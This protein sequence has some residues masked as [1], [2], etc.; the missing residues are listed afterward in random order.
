MNS[1][2]EGQADLERALRD[3]RV[4][5]VAITTTYYVSHLPLLEVVKFVRSIDATVPVIVGGPFVRTQHEVHSES[6]FRFL[7]RQIEADFYVVSD[8]G[9]QALVNVLA[10]IR[11]GSGYAGIPNLIYRDRDG[12]TCNPLVRED[13]DLGSNLVDWTLFGDHSRAAARRMV[14]VRTARSCPFACARSA[15]SRACGR[16]PLPGKIPPTSGVSSTTEAL[17]SVNSVTFIDDMFN[18]AQPVQGDSSRPLRAEIFVQVEL[19]FSLS[20]C[21]ARTRLPH[22][23]GRLRRRS[24]PGL[25]SEVTRSCAI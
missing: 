24:F 3:G 4:R 10:A 12:Y 13:N 5:A 18:A 1:F 6:S 22:E 9:E 20:V 14:M 25:E 21:D 15:V 17:G 11:S 8:Q 7:L 16:L 19:Q 23:G 2:Q